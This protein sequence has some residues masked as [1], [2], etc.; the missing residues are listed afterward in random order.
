MIYSFAKLSDN[1]L[2]AFEWN[3]ESTPWMRGMFER[4]MDLKKKNPSLKILIAVGGMIIKHF[5]F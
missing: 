2:T 3:D 5:I 4:T 1:V